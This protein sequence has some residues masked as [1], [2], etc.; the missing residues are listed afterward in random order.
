MCLLESAAQPLH[1]HMGVP[2]GGGEVRVAEQFLYRA[3]IRAAFQHV[4]RGAVSQG[5]RCD[6]RHSR[7]V[8]HP[9]DHTACHPSI[10][11][12]ASLANEQCVF[13]RC[14]D[15]NPHPLHA[16]RACCAGTP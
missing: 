12:A 10:D 8:A 2:L 16:S 4:G 7:G 3:Q 5:V 1:G 15:F 11:A 6:H 14:R 9:R 13:T